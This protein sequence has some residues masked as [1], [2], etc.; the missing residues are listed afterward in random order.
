L[1]KS[2]SAALRFTT[3]G[4][5]PQFR[6]PP[7]AGFRKAQLASEAFYCAVYFITFYEFISFQRPN[8]R[9]QINDL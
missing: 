6:A 9:G 2:P 1:V 4:A 5:G 7:E 8:H 3:L